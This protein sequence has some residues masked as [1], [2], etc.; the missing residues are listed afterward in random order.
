MTMEETFSLRR[1]GTGGPY[2]LSGTLVWPESPGP[3]PLAVICHGLF[4]SQDS[5]KLTRLSRRLAEAGVA[6]ARF[7]CLGLGRSGGRVADT[8]LSSPLGRAGEMAD[9]A[10]RLLADQRLAGPALLIGSSFG[11]TAALWLGADPAAAGFPVAGVATLA[12]PVDFAAMA[13]LHGP[14]LQAGLAPGFMADLMHADLKTRLAGLSHALVVHG[15]DDEVVPLE[16]AHL[17]V[18]WLAPP[19]R[20]V[21]VAQG[22]HRFSSPDAERTALDE[23]K[24]W[25]KSRLAGA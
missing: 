14:E 7:D 25:A 19:A 13:R 9:V 21:V 8:T 5:P 20:L 18:S 15:A 2:E 11:G 23:I 4:S 17:L 6:A 24:A 12:A 10:R 16:Q 3:H 22:D 1:T